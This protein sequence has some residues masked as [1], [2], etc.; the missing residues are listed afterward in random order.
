MEPRSRS[1]GVSQLNP[2]LNTSKPNPAEAKKIKAQWAAAQALLEKEQAAAGREKQGASSARGASE[3]EL[4][5]A[6][7]QRDVKRNKLREDE[8]KKWHAGIVGV[9]VWFL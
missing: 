2:R 3:K 9:L 7:K 1:T 5:K 4:L 8:F 6:V